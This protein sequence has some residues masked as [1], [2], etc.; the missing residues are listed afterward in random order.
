MF[1]LVKF[2]HINC[3]QDTIPQ[4]R[5]WYSLH[6]YWIMPPGCLIYRARKVYHILFDHSRHKHYI[7]RDILKILSY[8]GSYLFHQCVDEGKSLKQSYTSMW[9]CFKRACMILR[10]C[11][12]DFDK[13]NLGWIKR[14]AA[15]RHK[16][17]WRVTC[18]QSSFDHSIGSSELV[19]EIVL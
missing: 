17:K 12:S 9:S 16:I 3:L 2:S 1:V 14:C 11:K 4:L 18:S 8:C 10:S 15:F 19:L 5:I 7:S 13:F 6:V